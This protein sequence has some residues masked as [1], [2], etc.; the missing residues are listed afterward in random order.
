M[1]ICPK[2]GKELVPCCDHPGC[3]ARVE[4]YSRIV[5]YMRPISTWNP[6]KQ[7]EFADRKEFVLK[8]GDHSDEQDPAGFF[9]NPQPPSS[10]PLT[11]EEKRERDP[12][13]VDDIDP[14]PADDPDCEK[15]EEST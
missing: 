13:T 12:D 7:Q 6:G 3:T 9:D 15:K 14:G 5:G 8:H 4:V 10:L 11:E 1:D 2:C